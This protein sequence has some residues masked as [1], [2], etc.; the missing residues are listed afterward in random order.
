MNT[1]FVKKFTIYYCKLAAAAPQY[2]LLCIFPF[3]LMTAPQRVLLNGFNALL[4]FIFILFRLQ[5]FVFT[6]HCFTF[7]A[8]QMS[9]YQLQGLNDKLVWFPN[10]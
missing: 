5:C 3:C 8:I 2:G 9:I 6:Y 10:L 1:L 7:S 4:S